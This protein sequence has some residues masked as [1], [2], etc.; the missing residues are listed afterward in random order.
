M[1][2]NQSCNLRKVGLLTDK[3]EMYKCIQNN[4]FI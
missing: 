1:E 2:I 3:D 4:I